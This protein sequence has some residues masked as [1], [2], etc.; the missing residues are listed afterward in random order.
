MPKIE[1][2]EQ[3]VLPQGI[4]GGQ[5]SPMDFGA[6]IGQGMQQFGAGLEGAAN[7]LREHNETQDVTN[8]HVEMAKA[9]ATWTQNLQD[10]ENS[11]VP[12]DD[13]FAPKLMD[14][15]S[16]WMGRVGDQV[17]TQ[18]G[19]QIFAT[20]SANMVSEFGQRAISIQSELAAKDAVNKYD[21]LLE[22]FGKVAYSDPTQIGEAVNQAKFALDDPKGIFGKVPQPIRDKFKAKIE[23]DINLSASKGFIRR[24]GGAEAL[25][26]SVAPDM[27]LQFKPYEEVLKSNS[28]PG[29]A[30]DIRPGA[31]RWAPQATEAAA[32]KGVNPN[33]L[34]AQIDL[35]S[36]GNSGA[37]NA[38]SGAKGLAQ[39]TPDT[40]KQYGV[41]T[42]DPKSSIR[43]QA[44]YMSDLLS[45]F[46]GDYAKAVAAYNWGPGNISS[47][48][49]KWGD[50]WQ[51]HI[52]NETKDYVVNVLAKSG[53]VA[54]NPDEAPNVQL[55]EAPAEEA[56]PAT[57][58]V[59]STLPFFKN[60]TWE[61]Q[62]QVVKEAIQLQH[63]KLTMLNQARA[64]QEYQ[65]KKAQEGVMDGFLK[66]II[67]PK[68]YGV[69]GDPEIMT[70]NVLTWQQ[71]QH[72]VDYKLS[73]QRELN[74]AAESKV[75][76][77]EVRRLMLM[78]HAPDTDPSKTYNM[79]PVMESYRLG[80]ISTNE[81]KMLRTEVEQLKEG[82]SFTKETGRASN[83]VHDT[84]VKSLE[85]LGPRMMGE[86]GEAWYRFDKDMRD[87]IAEKRRKNEDPRV[88]L[89]PKS[90]E[91]LLA[92]ERL[93]QFIP[94]A[95]QSLEKAAAKSVTPPAGVKVETKVN[96]ANGKTYYK[97]PDG[98][99]YLTPPQ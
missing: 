37:V 91:Y 20:L 56:A 43:G 28:A 35:E 79:D 62:D 22:S 3:R 18:R 94:S 60:L 47:V 58:P 98:K 40:A 78:I 11:A 36:G 71:K 41:D 39:F 10:R 95:A 27:L 83:V 92:P 73:R 65:Q 38:K 8:V 14:D 17:K 46:G 61:Q 13:T 23:N 16:E 5:A 48:I 64:E 87:R 50:D 42:S 2:Y 70:N 19:R 77:T 29:A 57:T 12:G 88:L 99:Y 69:L 44:A 25:L 49:E 21:T 97:H 32:A 24:D 26:K 89:D 15:M 90:R 31:M 6:Q 67:Q 63:L 33:V 52:P 82:D 86:V 9:R 51:Q 66:R 54:P 7:A 34:L 76:P 53:S 68:E 59:D 4:L 81:M 74:S 75:N 80:R 93:R 55:A 45:R 72:L 30:V 84:F 96:P 85:F 1:P